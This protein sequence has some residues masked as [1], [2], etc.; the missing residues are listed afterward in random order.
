[1]TAP[2]GTPIYTED[3]L[4]LSRFKFLDGNVANTITAKDNTVTYLSPDF[5]KGFDGWSNSSSMSTA[6]GSNWATST[7]SGITLAK[8][9]KDWDNYTLTTRIIAKTGAAGVMFRTTD[10]QSGYMWQIVPG[11]GLKVHKQVNGKFTTLKNPIPCDI[12]AGQTYRMTINANGSV[13]K[14]YINGQLVDITDDNT[15]ATGTVG[16]RQS[17]TGNEVGQFSDVMVLDASGEV[18]FQDNFTNGLGQWDIS[19]TTAAKGSNL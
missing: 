4:D 6:D 1:M 10:A 17:T 2:D 3:F 19:T 13:I 5:S 16:F 15:Y 7:S 8:T 9:G 18:L 11:T 14:T 12:K